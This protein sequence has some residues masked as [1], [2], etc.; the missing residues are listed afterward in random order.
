MNL[1]QLGKVVAFYGR[2]TLSFTQVG[3]V[4]RRLTWPAF[5]ADY[6][7]QHWVVTGAS[8][9]LGAAIAQAALA[10]GARVTAVA[11]NASK[12]EALRASAIAAGLPPPEIECCDFS[13]QADTHALL[14]RLCRRAQ[15]VDVLVNNVGVLLDDHTLTTEGRETSYVTNLLSHYLLT[16]GLIRRG[17]M[18]S[19]RALVINMTS[20]GAYNVPL[21]AAM[22]NV[23]DPGVYHGTVAYAFHKRAQIVLNEH[24]RALYGRLGI[25]FYVMHPGWVDTDGVRRSLPRFRRL[26]KAVLRDAGSG[27]DTCL[28]LA[29][30]RPAQPAGESVWFDR[31]LRPAHVYRGTI[32]SRDTAATLVAALETDLAR[33][34]Q[35]GLPGAC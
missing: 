7:G 17:A 11:R 23:R 6:A 15:P 34:P 18:A 2:F 33:L 35:C 13:L 25:E 28:W 27:A 4:V 24:W 1:Q 5:K 19:G 26:F 32:A 8:A 16:E 14:E 3:F 21:S 9:G 22:L 31:K 20:G 10:A 30:T 29:S 12:L